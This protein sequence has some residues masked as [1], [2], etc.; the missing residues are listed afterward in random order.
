MGPW[1]YVAPRLDTALRELTP[2]GLPQAMGR[3]VLQKPPEISIEA[4]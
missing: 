3:F 4:I 2:E 1:S